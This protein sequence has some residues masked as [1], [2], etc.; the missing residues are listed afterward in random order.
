M[1]RTLVIIIAVVVSEALA[2]LLIRRVWRTDA[3]PVGKVAL[4]MLAMIPVAGPLFTWWV[5]HDPG[6]AHPAF[7]DN[8]RNQPDVLDR[9]KHV[10]DEQ[11]PAVRQRK[12]E[13]LMGHRRDGQV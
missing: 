1:D 6:P 7:R 9:W 13:E 11:D 2:L 4:S 5:G 3:H 12:W 10:F 8:S